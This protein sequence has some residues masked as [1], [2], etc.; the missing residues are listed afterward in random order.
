[1]KKAI[2][3]SDRKV[4]SRQGSY[5][6]QIVTGSNLKNERESLRSASSHEIP[7]SWSNKSWVQARAGHGRE[8]SGMRCS[9]LPQRR[10]APTFLQ[11]SS[12]GGVAGVASSTALAI[13]STSARAAT[14]AASTLLLTSVISESILQIP[15]V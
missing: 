6:D 13:T 2:G 8:H 1:M 4:R 7:S 3:L 5:H 11:H 12:A 14:V 9:R 10:H 15:V